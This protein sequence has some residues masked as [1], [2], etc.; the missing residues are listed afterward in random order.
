[1]FSR[2]AKFEKSLSNLHIYPLTLF[3]MLA[4]PGFYLYL[5]TAEFID[6]PK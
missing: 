1:M 6:H 4:L 2:L 3:M 5:C